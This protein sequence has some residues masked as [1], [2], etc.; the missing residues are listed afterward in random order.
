MGL[1]R[2][3]LRPALVPVLCTREDHR[4][5]LLCRKC[6]SEEVTCAKLN[7]VHAVRHMANS[8]NIQASRRLSDLPLAGGDFN[9]LSV[10]PAPSA[11]LKHN[12]TPSHMTL[13]ADINLSILAYDSHAVILM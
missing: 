5:A 2:S 9:E 6:Y 11:S 10:H 13:P 12:V 1:V 4:T 8:T 3:A 7:S